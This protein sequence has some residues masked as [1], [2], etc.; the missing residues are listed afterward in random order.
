MVK[1]SVVLPVYG[2]EEYIEACV[3]SLLKQTLDDVEFLFVDDCGPD[4]SI[5]LAKA[6][7][8]GHARE[9]QFRCLQPPHNLGAGMARNYGME[10]ATGEYVAFIDPDDT[11]EPNMLELLYTKAKQT[12]SDLC[13][14]YMRKCYPDGTQGEDMMNPHVGDGQLTHDKRAFVLTHYVSL[15]AS[16]IYRR[17]F[18]N[19]QNIRFPEDRAADDSFFVSC[20][21]MTAQSV[22]YVDLPLYH[23]LIRPGSVTT[24]LDSDKYK[25]RLAVFAKLMKYAEEHGV[26]NEFAAE[27]DYMYIKKGYLSS[28]A[29]YIRNSRKPQSSTY[30]IIHSELLSQ[31]PN[32]IHN[33]YYRRNYAMRMLVWLTRRCPMVATPVWRW[34]IKKRNI[35]S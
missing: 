25:K 16:M 2:V 11:V 3:D 10:A 1:V 9:S 13:C 31:V 22:A 4:K 35:I 5:A 24:T 33:R 17:S 8:A 6:A 18:L 21:W 19:E 12:D 29:N 7:V 34:Y 32:Y 20:A 23:Y 26:R 14:C 30:E 27:V 28:V 15:F